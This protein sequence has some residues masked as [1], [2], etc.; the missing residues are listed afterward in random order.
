MLGVC[1]RLPTFKPNKSP[2]EKWL[3]LLFFMK[4]RK[5]RT[6]SKVTV[7]V[8]RYQPTLNTTLEAPVFWN[9]RRFH[10]HNHWLGTVEFIGLR[11]R[12]SAESRRQ[13]QFI[14]VPKVIYSMCTAQN[15][16]ELRTTWNC[17]AV[18]YHGGYLGR[19]LARSKA[20]T[21]NFRVLSHWSSGLDY[22]AHIFANSSRERRLRNALSLCS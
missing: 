17:I 15:T 7:Q 20:W 1:L 12:V 3:L 8:V 13:L 21:P 11:W 19:L 6:C 5:V 2:L 4:N 22:Q 10:V 18:L 14:S 9:F 16:N